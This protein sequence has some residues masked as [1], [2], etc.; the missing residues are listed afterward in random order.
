[1]VKSPPPR[2]VM[3]LEVQIRPTKG[4]T[5]TDRGYEDNSQGYKGRIDRYNRGKHSTI[6]KLGLHT[7]QKIE[8]FTHIEWPIDE[9]ILGELEL[10]VLLAIGRHWRGI[11]LQQVTD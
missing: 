8:C 10:L 11:D 5:Q 9:E 2:Q 1:M 7:S 6:A 4:M 3:V